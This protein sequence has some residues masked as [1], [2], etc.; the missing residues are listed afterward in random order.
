M[1]CIGEAKEGGAVEDGSIP[2]EWLCRKGYTDSLSKMCARGVADGGARVGGIFA[3]MRIEFLMMIYK[4][5]AAQH[6]RLEEPDRSG[7]SKT[8]GGFGGCTEGWFVLKLAGPLWLADFR[9]DV[10]SFEVP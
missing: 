8:G 9:C 4:E 5:F 7:G 2:L 1:L 6:Q 10:T 3:T